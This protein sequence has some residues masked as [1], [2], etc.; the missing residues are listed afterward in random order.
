MNS[1][2]KQLLKP[3][4]LEGIKRALFIQPHPDDNEIGAGGTMAYLI[5]NGAEVYELTVTDDRFVAPRGADGLTVRQR[6]ALAAM[7][8]LGVKNAGFLGFA[9]KTR[10]SVEE[11]SAK[12]LPVIREIKPDA[13]FSVDP[14]LENECHSDH[15]KV[16]WAVRFCVL[17]AGCDFFPDMPEGKPR[18]DVWTVPILGQYYTANPNMVV[19]ISEYS[20][21]KFA[22]ISAHASQVSDE[23]LALLKQQDAVL[24]EGTGCAAAERLRLLSG[25]HMHCFVYPVR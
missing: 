20:E 7:K 2:F 1:T 10:A 3:P 24:A 4:S 12:I 21:K 18:G 8:V 25:I 11:L 23:F 22:A 5:K 15:I 19:D 6:E 9:D 13:V 14:T 17:D 16:G